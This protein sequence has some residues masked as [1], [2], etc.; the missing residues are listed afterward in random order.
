MAMPSCAGAFVSGNAGSNVCPSGSV[1]IEAIGACST[2]AAA[3]G[4]TE[5][6]V[7][8]GTDSAYPRGC[9]YSTLT[10][11][12]Y[13]NIHAAGAGNANARLLCATVTTVAPLHAPLTPTRGARGRC[14]E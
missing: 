14:V 6:Y 5:W 8:V 13:F 3:V 1:R 2:A 9:Y 7:F 4:K 10:N 11:A 12:A